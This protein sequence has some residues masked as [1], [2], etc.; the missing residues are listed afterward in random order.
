MARFSSRT[1]RKSLRRR[2]SSK[3]TRK[4]KKHRGG[5]NT[6]NRSIPSAAVLA[7]PL[8]VQ[9]YHGDDASTQ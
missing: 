8:N 1:F 6:L 9:E 4:I 2:R 5:G 7:N 3:K